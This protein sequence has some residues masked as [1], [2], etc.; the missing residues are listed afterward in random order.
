[1]GACLAQKPLQQTRHPSCAR[2]RQTPDGIRHAGPATSSPPRLRREPASALGMDGACPV[3]ERRSQK[4]LWKLLYPTK[5]RS[6]TEAGGAT[7]ALAQKEYG[8][9]TPPRRLRAARASA[10]TPPQE[11]PRPRKKAGRPPGPPST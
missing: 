4:W 10:P 1:M 8:L 9:A 2:R 3:A 7:T 5:S 6:M 11:E